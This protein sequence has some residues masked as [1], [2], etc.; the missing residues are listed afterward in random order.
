M[1]SSRRRQ[2]RRRRKTNDNFGNI[3]YLIINFQAKIRVLSESLAKVTEENKAL[4][5]KLK[6]AEQ[7]EQ[8]EQMAKNEVK[9]I[10]AI[11]IKCREL[12]SWKNSS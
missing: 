9:K 4:M 6:E 2:R 11:Y 8:K 3:H 5:E 1:S 12:H 10:I 7:K